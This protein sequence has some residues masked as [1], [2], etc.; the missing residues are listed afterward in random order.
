MQVLFENNFQG[1]AA[2]KVEIVTERP[3][4]GIDVGVW[5]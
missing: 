1:Y 2:Q 3:G 5:W 4:R